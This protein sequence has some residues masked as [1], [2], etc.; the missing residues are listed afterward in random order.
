MS[1]SQIVI[2]TQ[3]VPPSTNNLYTNVPGRGRVK[4]KR[5][6]AWINAAGWDFKGKGYIDGP[7]TCIITIDR[8][9]RHARADIDNKIKAVLDLL[10]AYSMIEND[11]LC[12][13][14]TIRWGDAP[15]GAVILLQKYEPNK[16]ISVWFNDFMAKIVR[17]EK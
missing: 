5:Y 16:G 12:E 6:K 3:Y 13:S 7:F 11:R 10:Q 9:K 15:D 8:S 14:A 2:H 17:N 4:T 1:K